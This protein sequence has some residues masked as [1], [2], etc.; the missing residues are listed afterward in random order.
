MLAIPELKVLENER[1]TAIHSPLD[2][3]PKHVKLRKSCKND[4]YYFICT[5]IFNLAKLA[6]VVGGENS[7]QWGRDGDGGGW[8]GL[9]GCQKCSTY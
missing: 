2:D 9:L 4:T 6:F 8:R 1:T 3:S 7:G 5:K